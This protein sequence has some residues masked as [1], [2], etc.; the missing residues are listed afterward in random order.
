[1]ISTK[2]VRKVALQAKRD[3]PLLLFLWKWKVATTAGLSKKFF[4]NLSPMTGYHRLWKLQKAGYINWRADSSGQKFVWH[5]TLKGFKAIRD[6]IP[7]AMKDQGYASEHIG[8]DLLTSAVHLGDW[9]FETPKDVTFVSEQQLRRYHPDFLPSW[10]PGMEVD[11]HRPDGYWHLP[12]QTGMRLVALEVEINPKSNDEYQKVAGFYRRHSGVAD[13]LW[14]VPLGWMANHLLAQLEKH[15]LDDK[16]KNHNF[17]LAED[18]K[19]FGWQAL[20]KCGRYH[21]RS[22]DQFLGKSSPNQIQNGS[23]PVC[24]Q[25]TLDTRKFPKIS[26]KSKIFGGHDFT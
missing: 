1:V 15:I 26:G 13:V 7:A 11:G 20:I 19:Q 6:Q 9:Y 3:L 21:G 14:V 22:V 23:K 8:H 25:F 10:I 4:A 18:F 12:S 5:L 2:P 24:T 16:N 17:I